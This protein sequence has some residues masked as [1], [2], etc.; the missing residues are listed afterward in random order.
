MTLLLTTTGLKGWLTTFAG[1][2]CA[3]TCLSPDC[4]AP[5][6]SPAKFAATAI[7]LDEPLERVIR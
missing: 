6:P 7:K 4:D 3:G 2:Q 1:H 5:M